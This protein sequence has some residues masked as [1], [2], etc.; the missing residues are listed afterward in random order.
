[1]YTDVKT[2]WVADFQIVRLHRNSWFA[3]SILLSDFPGLELLNVEFVGD[4]GV[5]LLVDINQGNLITILLCT[6]IPSLKW[7]NIAITWMCY[8]KI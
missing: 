4:G 1:M 3:E 7:Y 8:K 6:Q 2:Y 5:E